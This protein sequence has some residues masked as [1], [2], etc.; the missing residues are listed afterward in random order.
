MRVVPER[1]V[2]GSESFRA[3]ILAGR[4]RLECPVPGGCLF[5]ME[6]RGSGRRE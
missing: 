2:Q 3:G 6:E 1:L 5:G 4:W